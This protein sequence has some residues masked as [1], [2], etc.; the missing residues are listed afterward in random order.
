MKTYSVKELAKLSGVTSRTLR[1]YDQIGLLVPKREGSGEYRIYTSDDVD[2]LQEILLYRELG[3]ELSQIKEMI[4]GSVESR[5][6]R[7]ATHLNDLMARKELLDILIENVRNTIKAEKGEI[8]MT[9]DKKFEGLKKKMV[10][11]NEKKYGEEIR[12]KYGENTIDESNR[13]MMKLTKEEFEELKL[14]AAEINKKLEAA[15]T[16]GLS[17]DSEEGLDIARLHRKWL[18]FSW[19]SY[20]PEAHNGLVEMYIGDERFKKYYDENVDGCAQFLKDA[21]HNMV[22]VDYQV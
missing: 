11:D 18:D 9:D 16:N 1:H 6:S 21:V 13:K 15:V 5:Q 12:E 10:E 14:M 17:P 3:V 22:K 2:K 20:S 19:P 8:K 7:L 4:N